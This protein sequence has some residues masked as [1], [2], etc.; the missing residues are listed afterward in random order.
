MKWILGIAG[1]VIVAVL[2]GVLFF[3]RKGFGTGDGSGEGTQNLE[4]EVSEADIVQKQKDN[5]Y[6]LIK[7]EDNSIL[8]EEKECATVEELK[9]IIIEYQAE[10]NEKEYFFEHDQAIKSTYDE[11]KKILIDLEETLEIKVQYN[12]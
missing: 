10:G 1:L 6:I 7:V 8:I 11:V 3:G 12:D 9:N 5:D 4:K 2:V